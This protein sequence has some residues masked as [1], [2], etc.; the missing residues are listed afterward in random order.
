M[1]RVYRSSVKATTHKALW[2]AP[3]LILHNRL[4]LLLRRL[5]ILIRLL[6]LGLIPLVILRLI[7]L[8]II[9]RL[10]HRLLIVLI[11]LMLLMLILCQVHHLGWTRLWRWSPRNINPT[12]SRAPPLP[13]HQPAKG[14]CTA[15]FSLCALLV[16]FCT[17]PDLIMSLISSGL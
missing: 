1:P 16:E 5:L 10:I 8:M 13:R 12:K 9:F 3:I 15:S 6:I 2:K 4:S 17:L 14:E 7:S 11:T